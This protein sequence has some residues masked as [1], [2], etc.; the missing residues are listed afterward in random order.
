MKYFVILA[1]YIT[2]LHNDSC[3]IVRCAIWFNNL[4]SGT[5]DQDTDAT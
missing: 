3:R 4:N 1:H 2:E 5:H